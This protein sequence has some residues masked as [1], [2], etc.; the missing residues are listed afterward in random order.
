MNVGEEARK[1]TLVGLLMEWYMEQPFGVLKSL[2]EY[3]NCSISLI[4]VFG[5][6]A[7]IVAAFENRNRIEIVCFLKF[8]VTSVM[9]NALL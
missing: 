6:I 4:E 9:D 2:A 7:I 3:E 5:R 1:M 8:I